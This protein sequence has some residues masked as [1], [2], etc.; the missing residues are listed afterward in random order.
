MGRGSPPVQASLK[1]LSVAGASSQYL[2]GCKADR[3][4]KEGPGRLAACRLP[5]SSSPLADL[6]QFVSA[7]QRQSLFNYGYWL[8]HGHI[9]SVLLD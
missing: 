2:L 4:K 1:Q 8:S 3:A 6:G 9:P 7:E 5:H